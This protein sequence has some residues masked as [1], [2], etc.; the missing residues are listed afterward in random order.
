MKRVIFFLPA[1]CLCAL[2]LVPNAFSAPIEFIREI[3]DTGK[4]AGQQRFAAPQA[5]ALGLSKIYIA[6]TNAHRVVVLDQTGRVL[7]TWGGQ[8]GDPGQFRSPAGIALDEDGR[9]YVADT[10]NNRIQVFRASRTS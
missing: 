9:V 4:K 1:A 7:Q 2:F 10:K 3:G 5:L 6:D 8:G